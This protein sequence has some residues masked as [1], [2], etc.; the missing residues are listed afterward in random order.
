MVQNRRERVI[1]ELRTG[2]S[3]VCEAQIPAVLKRA[4]QWVCWRT[5]DRGETSTKVPVDPITGRYAS[6][7]DPETWSDYATAHTYCRDTEEVEGVGFV[8][9]ADDP[10]PGID[11]DDC[12]DPSTGAVADWAVDILRQLASYT[13]RSPSGTGFHVIVKGAVP[14]GGNRAGNLEMYDH[15]RFFTMTGDR[16]PG[17]PTTVEERGDELQAIHEAFIADSEPD[18]TDVPPEARPAVERSDDELLERARNAANGDKFSR[19]YD[20]GDTSDYD[21]HSEADLALCTLLAFW[22]GGDPQ[23]I[24]AM[25]NRSD[26][27]R[28]RWRDRREYREHTIRN[29]IRY[30]SPFY[31]RDEEERPE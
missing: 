1:H 7:T 11:L 2:G 28:D 4:D 9:T 23:R 19:L 24:E 3:D 29:A 10:Y 30:C 21:S 18:A 5:E 8:F 16:V 26:L 17:A 31:S 25:F 14:D 15:A 12:R 13:E 20:R 22:T 27:V 6:V